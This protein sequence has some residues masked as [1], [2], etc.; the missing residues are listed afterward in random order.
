MKTMEEKSAQINSLQEELSD[1]HRERFDSFHPTIMTLI[2]LRELSDYEHL[3]YE[4]RLNLLAYL[5]VTAKIQIEIL[6]ELQSLNAQKYPQ[7]ATEPPE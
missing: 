3:E 7:D 5:H 2:H 1:L 6:K 4:M